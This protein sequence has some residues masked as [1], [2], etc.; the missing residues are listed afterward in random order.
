MRAIQKQVDAPDLLPSIA[1]E[2][3]DQRGRTTLLDEAIT[4]ENTLTSSEI[5]S[6]IE[7]LAAIDW[8]N[9][10]SNFPTEDLDVLAL[11]KPVEGKTSFRIGFAG[12][13]D[14]N[15]IIT[16]EIDIPGRDTAIGLDRY[17]LGYSGGFSF[18]IER[19]RWEIELGALY[20]VRSYENLPI[21]ALAGN[22]REGY[23]GVSLKKNELNMLN[24]P[25]HFRYNVFVHDK[26]RI[27]ALTGGS[28]SSILQANYYVVNE[29]A[30]NLN[31]APRPSTD[32][33]RTALT[34]ELLNSERPQ[35]ILEGGR[36]WNNTSIQLDVGFGLERYMSH[37]WSIFAQP[38]YQHA[39]FS[40]FRGF[41]PYRD[42]IHS[43]SILMGMKVK[44]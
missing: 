3:I 8:M 36:F 11:L 10:E 42:R 40:P 17:S 21:I 32:G 37:R 20:A 28:I 25:L 27:Y 12:S 16:P 38:T 43:M 14:Y 18:G 30:F 39:V 34:N 31:F 2:G 22:I 26:W 7:A 44:L 15:R 13:P 6:A 29:E 33:A 4:E 5:K 19:G 23:Q 41:G 9:P 35:G 24:V 1:I